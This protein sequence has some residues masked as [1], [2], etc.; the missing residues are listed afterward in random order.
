[1]LYPP[2]LTTP[3]AENGD[4]NTIPATNDPVSGAASQALG[5]PPLTSTPIA[6]GG[7]APTREDF[8][9]LLYALSVF[10]Y[11]WQSGGMM[12]WSEE[13][14][15]PKNAQITY[16]D[17]PY[18][19]LDESGPGSANGPKQPNENPEFWEEMF[20]GKQDGPGQGLSW[21]IAPTGTAHTPED[22]E[23]STP[24]D[25]YSNH[26]T[27]DPEDGVAAVLPDGGT[28]IVSWYEATK[29]SA[30]G[31]LAVTKLVPM[32]AYPGGTT[33]SPTTT[34]QKIFCDAWRVI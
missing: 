13:N 15:Y 34:A 31:A 18:R 32:R 28:W 22:S 25:T 33:I 20:L 19:A 29:A 30:N 27:D 7:V 8:N 9:G 5:F 21:A 26:A 4:K 12:Q 24:G 1:M 10:I 6:Q 14:D 23:E 11:Y 2:R 3:I 17:V 16:E